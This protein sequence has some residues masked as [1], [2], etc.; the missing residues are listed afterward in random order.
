[1]AAAPL[2]P[3]AHNTGALEDAQMARCGG[4]TVLKV[5]REVPGR[6]LAAG[7]AQGQY[8]V[9]AGLVGQ[10]VEHGVCFS[11][12]RLVPQRSYGSG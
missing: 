9:A 11:E 3:D 2:A 12:G 8:E 7:M 1:M 10:G 6:E 4:P 5:P